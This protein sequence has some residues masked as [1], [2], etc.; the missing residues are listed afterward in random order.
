MDRYWQ[1][2]TYTCALRPECVIIL[3]LAVWRIANAQWLRLCGTFAQG[4]NVSG[5]QALPRLELK[6]STCLAQ[7]RWCMW[8]RSQTSWVDCRGLLCQLEIL[9]LS[10]TPWGTGRKHAMSMVSATGMVSQDLAVPSFTS[11]PG[12]WFGP[13]TM[14]SIL[15]DTAIAL[16]SVWFSK[17]KAFKL[18]TLSILLLT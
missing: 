2:F 17:D 8:S 11:T 18:Y 7:T 12:P 14:P 15:L 1:I 6:F 16:C 3:I 10:P 4:E 9:G 5:G 13:L